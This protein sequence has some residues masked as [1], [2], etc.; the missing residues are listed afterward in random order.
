MAIAVHRR[1]RPVSVLRAVDHVQLAMPAGEEPAARA[2][3]GGVLGLTEVPKPPSLAG[4]GGAWFED[5]PLKVHLGVDPDFRP[6]RKAHV[7]FRVDDVGAV[8]EA[9]RRAGVPVVDDDLLPGHDRAYVFDPF[10]N[11]IEVLCPF[12]ATG[13]AGR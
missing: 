1:R 7:A 9:C 12:H 3:Y 11:R 10:G 8:V 2:F 6:A 5:G 13:P 4:R